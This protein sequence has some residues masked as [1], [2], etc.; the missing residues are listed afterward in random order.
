MSEHVAPASDEQPSVAPAEGWQPR[1]GWEPT[2]DLAR[3]LQADGE[4]VELPTA[5]VEGEPIVVD[6]VEFAGEKFRIR[7]RAPVMALLKF[8]KAA[9]AGGD[10]E[11]LEGLA[12]MYALLRGC[13][14]T[15]DWQRFEDLAMELESDHEE[16]FAVVQQ[17]LELLTSRPTK[18]PNDSSSGPRPISGSSRGRSRLA[19]R[20]ADRFQ[21]L[22]AV[23]S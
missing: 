15:Q 17:T 1:E 4:G 2:D 3:I 6:Q 20:E 19:E 22:R 13:I 7:R 9:Q 11:N 8:A 12:A 21:G 5:T 14:D 10:S 18:R 23:G 16:L